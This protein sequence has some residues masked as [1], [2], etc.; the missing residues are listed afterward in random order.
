MA[1]PLKTVA[2]HRTYA[3]WRAGYQRMANVDAAAVTV[4]PVAPFA[5]PVGHAPA[6]SVAPAF[7]N[8]PRA[9]LPPEL[10]DQR[11]TRAPS[12]ATRLRAAA[13]TVAL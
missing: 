10:V 3:S 11:T 13:A 8:C 1:E 6:R 7:L 5:L 2:Q 12:A 9:W 4:D